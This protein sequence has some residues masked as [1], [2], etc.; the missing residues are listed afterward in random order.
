METKSYSKE[1]AFTIAGEASPIS[2]AD[3]ELFVSRLLAD[4]N[5]HLSKQEDET[6]EITFHEPFVSDYPQH[7]KEGG[8]QRTVALRSDVK[9]DSE[10]VEYMA[11]GHPVIDDLMARATSPAYSGSA[12]AF[13][14]DAVDLPPTTGWLI[15]YE[16]GVPAL[17][18]VR[19]LTPFF[20]DDAGVVDSDL[21]H[22]LL[23]RAASFPNDHALS[24]A[25][26]PIDSL[27]EALA[28]AETAGF[29]ATC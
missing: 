20:I 9:P 12:A 29:A 23:I 16:L 22:R 13:E 27:D 14:V 7:A 28:A 24:P 11:L 3:Q 21:G 4:V 26:I 10:H 8:R 6:F 2:P 18:E 5:T 15:V 1:I 25:D 17:K 19:E